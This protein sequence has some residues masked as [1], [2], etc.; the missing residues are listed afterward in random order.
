MGLNLYTK[1]YKLPDLLL[2]HEL[3]KCLLIAPHRGEITA[4]IPCR[5]G[6]RGMRRLQLKESLRRSPQ[7]E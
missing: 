1:H 2:R 4:E 7:T 5:R 3:L 6:E